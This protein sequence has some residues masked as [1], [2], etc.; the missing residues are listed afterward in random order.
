MLRHKVRDRFSYSIYLFTFCS[1]DVTVVFFFQGFELVPSANDCCHCQPIPSA[2]SLREKRER[3]RITDEDGV[4]CVS[5]RKVTTTF[6]EGACPSSDRSKFI[7]ANGFVSHERVC[8][9]CEGF[10]PREPFYEEF[11]CRNGKNVYVAIQNFDDCECDI[12]VDT[13]NP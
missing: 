2:C 1:E 13:S 6:C 5:R 8:R 11:A 3:V 9:C 10:K 4:V 7:F 12:C